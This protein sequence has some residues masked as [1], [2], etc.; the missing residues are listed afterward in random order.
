[1][2]RW[3]TVAV[4]LLSLPGW[5]VAA[6]SLLGYGWVIWVLAYRCTGP[7]AY[8]AYLLSAYALAMDIAALPGLRAFLKERAAHFKK[9]SR[10]AAALRKTALGR[11]YLDS[12]LFRARFSLYQGMSVNLLYTVFRAVTGVWYGSAWFLSIAAYHFLLGAL[13]AYLAFRYRHVPGGEDAFPYEVNSYKTVGW[14][15]LLLN[16]PMSGMVVLMVK[17]NSGFQYPG[18]VIYLSALYTF[19]MAVMSAVSLVKIRRLKSPILLAGKILHFVSA[20][21]SVLGLQTAM[22][23]RFGKGDGNFRQLMNT[24]TGAGVCA[25]AIGAGVFMIAKSKTAWRRGEHP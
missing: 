13:R 23:A 9:H 25:L 17:E 12:P 2:K 1:M 3:K 10:A 11:Q 21:M 14:L 5:I 19:Y 15:L 22:I 24:I 6:V 20:A 7:L 4:R 8:F 18:V 16:I